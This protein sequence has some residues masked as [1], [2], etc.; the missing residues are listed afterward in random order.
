MLRINARAIGIDLEPALA[1]AFG[2]GHRV[3]GKLDLA[4]DLSAHGPPGSLFDAL[5][6]PF[7]IAA[8]DGQFLEATLMTRLLA[9]LNITDLLSGA[10]AGMED[11]SV[12]YRSLKIGADQA[13]RMLSIRELVM[14]SEV[15]DLTG[16]GNISLVDRT[17]DMTLLVAP[18]KVGNWLVKKIPLLR[19]IMDGMLVTIAVRA[20]GALDDPTVTVLPAS[21]VG[22]GLVGITRRALQ[23]PFKIIEPVIGG[24]GK[25]AQ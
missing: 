22:E 20:T 2:P 4:A 19:D 9:L 12:R 5:S 13:R 7:T 21:A 8:R 15:M 1:C 16:R 18:I 3:S 25:Q 14:D 23:L 11:R 24:D 17:L 10:Y 6:G